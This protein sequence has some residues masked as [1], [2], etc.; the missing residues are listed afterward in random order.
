MVPKGLIVERDW[1]F[2]RLHVQLGEDLTHW[3]MF[4]DVF[5]RVAA[6]IDGELTE[7]TEKNK[8]AGI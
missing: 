1:G 7:L 6:M 4:R 8:G 3:I 2:D 5:R